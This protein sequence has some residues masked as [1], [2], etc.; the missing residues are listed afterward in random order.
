MQAVLKSSSPREATGPVH[1][2]PS[3]G[4]AIGLLDQPCSPGPSLHLMINSSVFGESSFV[5]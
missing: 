4:E 5:L 1:K 2:K 3:D